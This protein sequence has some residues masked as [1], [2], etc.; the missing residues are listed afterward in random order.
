[1]SNK[2]TI[3]LAFIFGIIGALLVSSIQNFIPKN[4]NDLIKEFYLVENAV[5]V[6]PH[7]I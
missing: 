5:H 6:S 4:N 1:M 7:S 2:K 3:I